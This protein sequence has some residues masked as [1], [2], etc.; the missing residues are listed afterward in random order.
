MWRLLRALALLWLLRQ[1]FRLLRALIIAA[2]LA[3]LWPVT[4]AAAAV[5]ARTWRAAVLAPVR[6]WQQA[7]ALLLHAHPARAVLI[8]APVAVPAGLLAGGAVW[9]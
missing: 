2:V 6:D 7:S 9:A 1:G 5:Q 4:L 3:A 8:T